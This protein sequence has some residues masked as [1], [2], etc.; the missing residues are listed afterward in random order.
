MWSIEAS[1]RR[2]IG[3]T[4]EERFTFLMQQLKIANTAE[5]VGRFVRPA[6]VSIHLQSEIVAAGGT[7]SENVDGLA[8]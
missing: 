7:L 8:D 5:A 1:R 6:D 2:A 3:R 4:L